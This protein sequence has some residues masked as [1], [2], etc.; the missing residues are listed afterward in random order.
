MKLEITQIV[1]RGVINKE[2]LW[3]KVLANTNLQYFV[4]LSTFYISE[5]SISTFPKYAYWFLS[6]EVKT[7]DNVILYTGSGTPSTEINNMGSTNHFL[8]WNLEKT[9][10]NK[11]ED[12]AVLFEVNTWQ[13]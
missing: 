1:D 6:K 11:K 10:W 4:V 13:T 2:R 8:Y 9:I 5:N 7:G 3:L 12:C